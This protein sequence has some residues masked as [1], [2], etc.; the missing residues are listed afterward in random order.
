[1]EIEIL[2]LIK[3]IQAGALKDAKMCLNPWK[4]KIDEAPLR[5]VCPIFPFARWIFRRKLTVLR[6][7]RKSRQIILKKRIHFSCEKFK[8][9][10]KLVF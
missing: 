6:S 3:N 4:D 8:K 5:L 2:G 1:M 7:G 10:K 9:K